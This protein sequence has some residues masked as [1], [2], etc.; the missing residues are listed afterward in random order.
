MPKKTLKPLK[1]ETP[2]KFADYLAV[3]WDELYWANW[4]YDIFKETGRLCHEHQGI[5]N[6]SPHFWHSTLRAHCQTALVY[7]HRV[8]DQNTES[9]CLHR[10][11]LTVRENR[12]IF[13]P[14]EVRNRRTA[15]LHA[16]DLIQRI[17]S[18]DLRQ[19]DQ[20]IAFSSDANPKVANLKRW[21]DRMT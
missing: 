19:L 2:K 1:L 4:Y 5:F 12:Q 13:D 9:F 21:R 11:L 14:V 6:Q 20:D 17:G 3:L 15:D 10:F 7:L 16:D 8:Y 18:L